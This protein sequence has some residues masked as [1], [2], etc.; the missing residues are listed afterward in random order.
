VSEPVTEPAATPERLDYHALLDAD[1]RL[2]PLLPHHRKILASSAITP[3]V[4]VARGYRSVT[5][6]VE[7]ERLGFSRPQRIV[8][9]LLLPV[10]DVHGKIALY[11]NRPDTPRIVDGKPVKYEIPRGSKMLIDVPP[12]ALDRIRDPAVPLFVTEGIKK[13]DAAVSKGLC[14]IDLLGVWNFRGTNN[15]GGKTALGDWDEIAVNGRF[16]YIV[17]D[18]D[19]M[20]KPSVARALARLK[21]LLETRDA[22]V[23]LIYLPAASDG[24]KVGMDDFFAAGHGRD[25]LLRLA[26]SKILYPPSDEFDDSLYRATDAGMFRRKETR[27]GIVDVPLTNFRA[28]IIGEDILDDGVEARR[29]FEIETAIHGRTLVFRVPSTKFESLTWVP[30]EIGAEAVVFAGNGTRDHTRAAIQITSGEVSRSTSFVH[31]GWREIDG[32]MVYLHA[33]GA[34]G[35]KGSLPDVRV[36]LPDSLRLFELPDP[37]SGG[38][39]IRCIRAS[40]SILEVADPTSTVPLLTA[41]YRSV[42]GPSDFSI[43]L[44]GPTGEG[45][46]ELAALVQQHFGRGMDARHLPASWSSTGNALEATAFSAKD[47][48]LTIDD[49]APRGNLSDAQ[50]LYREADRILR[51]QGN[52]LGRQRMTSDGRM[53]R[54]RPPRGTT[55]STG[56]DVPP[57]HSL[58]ARLLVV[59][60]PTKSMKWDQ[61]SKHQKEAADGVYATAMAGFVQYIAGNYREILKKAHEAAIEFRQQ[62][63]STGSHRRTPAAIAELGAGLEVFLQFA[64]SM[65]ALTA[66]ESAK[67]WDR[68]WKVLTGLA[69]AQLLEQV[70]STP[71]ERF[72]ELL[73]AAVA[74]GH[75]HVADTIGNFPANAS[76]W[77][78]R[79]EDEKWSF[80]GDRVG[81]VEKNNLYL[82]PHVCYAVVQKMARESGSD[83]LG[84]SERGLRKRLADAGILAS[85]ENRGSQRHLSVRVSLEGRRRDVLHVAAAFLGDPAPPADTIGVS[86]GLDV[87]REATVPTNDASDSGVGGPS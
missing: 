3:D 43:H 31:T 21:A 49:F 23:E 1:E 65:G 17:Y 18:S 7:L 28:R 72:R 51:A 42:L 75:A 10:F 9:S 25:D 2:R 86:V 64:M 37:P 30:S 4:A 26:Q 36:E 29:E 71:T 34:I 24:S 68:C 80:R 54:T 33:G 84:I 45:K 14:S 15:L 76:A 83:A 35:A 70:A 79:K 22:H 47:A 78:W 73:V 20:T 82:E 58:R 41:V 19:V 16:V 60:M 74:A 63:T 13:A 44:T 11:Q 62:S 5:R 87:R 61:L 66:E 85:T 39:M 40:L 6:I 12:G 81:W 48:L 46:T 67:T 57:G 38:E 50:R 53:R 55:L 56:E 52:N 32:E 8:P 59:E 27:E 77:G 69:G